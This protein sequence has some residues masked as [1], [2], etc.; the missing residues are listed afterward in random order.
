M[1]KRGQITV[2]IIIGIMVLLLIAII[3]Y[4]QKQGAEIRP[5]KPIEQKLGPVEAYI[6]SCIE[7]L[8]KEAV[9]KMGQSGG[10]VYLPK[11]VDVYP[12]AHISEDALGMLKVPMWYYND[13]SYMPS[14]EEM[15]FQISL[16]LNNSIRECLRN[17]E[18][19]K[20]EYDIRETGNP[21]F[22]V[23]IADEDVV[24]ETSYPLDVNL[25]ARQEKY[26]VE[27][28]STI[29]PVRLKRV[30]SL[31]RAIFEEE[32]RENFL[33]NMTLQ[34]MTM[35]PDVPFT[36]LE[37]RCTSREWSVNKIKNEVIDSIFSNFQRIRFKNT[38]YI[39]FLEP[40][41]EYKK[42]K[43]LKI[44]P[45]TGA[46]LNMPKRAPPLDLYEYFHF[47]FDVTSENYKDLSV[48]TIFYKEWPVTFNAFP[49][50]NGRMRSEAL[51]GLNFLKFFC[52]ETWHFIYDVSFPV[53]FAIR[54]P[55]SFDGKGYIFKFGMPVIIVHNR[56]LK[57]PL[58][59]RIFVNPA[60]IG[61]PCENLGGEKIDIRAYD[62]VTREELSR[63][64]I[65]YQCLNFVCYLGETRA[66]MGVN[67]L[68]TQLP[69]GCANPILI[70]E[71]ESYI[72]GKTVAPK[73]GVAEI[74]LIPLKK[75]D[76]NVTKIL[77]INKEE[78][79]L[80]PDEV[81]LIMLKN[82]KYN[83]EQNV[84]YPDITGG[85]LSQLNLIYDTVT[86][87]MNI[88]I[89]KGNNYVGGWA[90]NWTVSGKDLYDSNFIMFKVY[91]KIPYPSTDEETIDMIAEVARESPKYLPEFSMKK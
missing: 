34:L 91:E 11:E 41:S 3:F 45:K 90:G 49:S 38:N 28:F 26:K 73:T 71:K 21:V 29:I 9:L 69:V 16:Y 23:T 59:A 33:E 66:D 72:A 63:A 47:F 57:L 1:K 13:K 39:P 55:E 18:P 61:Q 56:P 67:R 40:E 52:M 85:N 8:G 32:N 37:F 42:F 31:A 70:A 46:V 77:S 19:L 86:Y 44:D 84:V 62:E 76:F 50:E 60:I 5:K 35:N 4:F 75:Y 80:L 82:K 12:A 7:T 88:F 68:R 10:Y 20:N 15:Q 65:S 54:D 27:K 24:I 83:Y 48:D 51:S 43:G 53:E 74:P 25:K 14:I 6:S 87:E 89:S 17:F 58:S 30:Y 22:T 78:A 36:G 2:F 64:N 81:V 79:S